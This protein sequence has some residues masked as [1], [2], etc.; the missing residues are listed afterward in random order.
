MESPDVLHTFYSLASL[1]LLGID[2][3]MKFDSLL[4]VPII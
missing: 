2:D 3:L 4:A 1:A